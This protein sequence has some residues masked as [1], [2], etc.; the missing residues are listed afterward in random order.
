MNKKILFGVFL[1]VFLMLM[2]PINSAVESDVVEN[3]QTINKKDIIEIR[4]INIIYLLLHKIKNTH[5]ETYN[6][7]NKKLNEYKNKDSDTKFCELLEQFAKL[8]TILGLLSYIGWII[9]WPIIRFIMVIGY[10]L[11]CEW[12][13]KSNLNSPKYILYLDKF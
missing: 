2:M 5:P 7:I 8:L 1:A 11:G 10:I 3:N 6:E 13:Y 12:I 9:F 4:L